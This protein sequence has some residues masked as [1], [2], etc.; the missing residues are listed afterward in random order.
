M[1]P[2]RITESF[3]NNYEYTIPSNAKFIVSYS[4]NNEPKATFVYGE[5]LGSRHSSDI[6]ELTTEALID[7]QSLYEHLTKLD[8]LQ[9]T[10]K[11]DMSSIEVTPI[12]ELPEQN[13]L[14]DFFNKSTEQTSHSWLIVHVL[15]KVITA[16]RDYK[17][18]QGNHDR[19]NK[20]FTYNETLVIKW[21][22]IIAFGALISLVIWSHIIDW[23]GL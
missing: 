14:D 10:H 15:G 6:F 16:F 5:K 9:T 21:L 12:S 23:F 1:Q 2:Y 20:S 11:I 19:Y 4:Q 7:K 13:R 18:K 3:P 17:M 8:S 22:F